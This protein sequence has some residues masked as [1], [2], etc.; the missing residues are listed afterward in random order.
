MRC[1]WNVTD[2]ETRFMLASQISEKREIQ[3]ARRIFQRDKERI[4]DQRV[5]RVVTDG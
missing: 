2:K 5:D 1:P 3:E 4:K